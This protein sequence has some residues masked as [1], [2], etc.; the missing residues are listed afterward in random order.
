LIDEQIS[1]I[2]HSTPNINVIVTDDESKLLAVGDKGKNSNI[3][4]YSIEKL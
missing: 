2:A 4:I 3:S 1:Y